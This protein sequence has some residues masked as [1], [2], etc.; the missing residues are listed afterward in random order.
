MSDLMN[1]VLPGLFVGRVEATQD[2]ESMSKVDAVLTVL[3]EDSEDDFLD[4]ALLE[5]K[6]WMFIGLRDRESANIERY[7]EQAFQFI[8][9]QRRSGKVVLVHCAAGRSRS[10]SMVI[11]YMMR[12]K[13]AKSPDEALAMIQKARPVAGPNEGFMEKLRKEFPN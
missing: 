6:Q 8:D 4:D 12:K 10:V 5:G 2:P 7:F 9:S 11:Y 1:E 3:R 13:L